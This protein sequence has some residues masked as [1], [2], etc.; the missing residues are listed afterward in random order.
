MD[1]TPSATLTERPVP[2]VTARPLMITVPISS[3][4]ASRSVLFAL[5]LVPSYTAPIVSSL[6]RTAIYGL[7][8]L[9]VKREAFG[10]FIVALNPDGT[11]K[12]RLLDGEDIKE[13]TCPRALYHV[14]LPQPYRCFSGHP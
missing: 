4:D 11:A 8:V 13:F 3:K 5:C 12:K 1:A 14:T 7:Q 2:M 10:C 9:I 6:K